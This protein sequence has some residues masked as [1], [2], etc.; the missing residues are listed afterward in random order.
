[1]AED[2]HDKLAALQAAIASL[3]MRV[4]SLESAGSSAATQFGI[5]SGQRP[6]G[7]RQRPGS[8][9]G[10]SFATDRPPIPTAAALLQRA[11]I[12][13]SL[14]SLE[15]PMAA[16]R[17]VVTQMVSSADSTGAYNVCI[18]G[19]VLSWIDVAAGLAAKVRPA[20]LRWEWVHSLV[21]GS[22]EA[23]RR[24]GGPPTLST[25][26]T[27]HQLH[28]LHPPCCPSTQPNANTTHRSCC[29]PWHVGPA[30][31]PAWTPCTFFAPAAWAL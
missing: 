1:M 27:T 28:Q 19:A 15:I 9:Q 11:P 13:S 17:I 22:E 30:S 5:S 10:T 4:Q 12:P 29:R 23:A 20:T 24:R 18:G 7:A 3:T 21:H 16:T 8:G 14:E 31:P 25:L 2:E 6:A 26:F